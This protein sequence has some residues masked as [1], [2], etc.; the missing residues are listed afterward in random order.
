MGG[1]V[2]SNG[3]REQEGPLDMDQGVEEPK[4]LERTPTQHQRHAVCQMQQNEA[5]GLVDELPA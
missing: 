3:Q 1:Q 2:Q 4:T 5:E